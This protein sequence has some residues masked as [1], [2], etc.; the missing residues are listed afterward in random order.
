MLT[1]LPG[2]TRKDRIKREYT[3]GNLGGGFNSTKKVKECHLRQ[4]SCTCLR[5]KGKGVI[6]EA[7]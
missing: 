1:G 5:D 2:F 7:K 4:F 3:R 6:N